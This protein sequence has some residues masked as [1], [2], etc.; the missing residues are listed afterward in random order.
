MLQ[1]RD[2]ADLFGVNQAA[3]CVVQ[4]YHKAVA[5]FRYVRAHGSIIPMVVLP[6]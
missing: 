4:G 1:G 2:N 5:L 3:P 6:R